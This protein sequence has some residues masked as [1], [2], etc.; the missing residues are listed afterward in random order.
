METPFIIPDSASMARSSSGSSALADYLMQRSVEENVTGRTIASL[1]HSSGAPTS[2]A[3]EP[4]G[5]GPSRQARGSSRQVSGDESDDSVL[6][7][8]EERLLDTLVAHRQSTLPG[9]QVS[10]S[11]YVPVPYTPSL[12]PQT[13]KTVVS[14]YVS[15]DGITARSYRPQGH[16]GA[17]VAQTPKGP[18]PGSSRLDSEVGGTPR[19]LLDM[20]DSPV[21]HRDDR[22]RLKVAR[23]SIAEFEQEG[24]GS[25]GGNGPTVAVSHSA[26]DKTLMENLH[27]ENSGLQ[28]ENKGLERENQSLQDECR[29]LHVNNATLA[30]EKADLV[31]QTR[32]C[33]A[34]LQRVQ[35]HAARLS[36][37]NKQLDARL[38]EAEEIISASQEHSSS[39]MQ[40]QTSELAELRRRSAKLEE[41][42]DALQEAQR[43]FHAQLLL[44]ND[45]HEERLQDAETRRDKALAAVHDLS[46]VA[47][48][49]TVHSLA[50]S[51]PSHS[52]ALSLP[53][54]RSPSPALPSPLIFTLY[55]LCV[56][57]CVCARV[58]ARA[59]ILP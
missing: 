26:H 27:L 18:P 58:C 42:R 11:G 29:R 19:T 49:L 8:E 48:W 20:P 30:K 25:T 2:A 23:V 22:V 34:E 38:K 31:Q 3:T 32:E 9:T 6:N 37:T 35:L 52:F 14:E 7:E 44:Q 36:T 5:A 55:R 54:P 10:G 53:P 39:V 41:E 56:C 57:A 1:R 13:P 33:Q 50:L 16:A 45:K 43:S 46:Q 28:Q 40:S 21:S 17:A 59:S 15:H 4:K 24:S 51:A 12:A 47:P